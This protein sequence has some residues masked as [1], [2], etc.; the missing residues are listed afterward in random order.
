MDCFKGVVPGMT[1]VPQAISNDTNATSSLFNLMKY[2]NDVYI[3]ST[4]FKERMPKWTDEAK[5]Q[6]RRF[7]LAL[8]GENYRDDVSVAF[9]ACTLMLPFV[10]TPHFDSLNPG[11]AHDITI[12]G[13]TTVNVAEFSE[14][15]QRKIRLVFGKDVRSIPFSAVFYQRRKL[16][17]YNHHILQISSFLSK[18]G[19]DMSARKLAIDAIQNV[20]SSLN[21]NSRFFTRRGYKD[22]MMECT[23]ENE[24]SWF[25]GK[26]G[27]SE[28][29]ID[30]MVSTC[31]S[32]SLIL[33]FLTASSNYLH[34]G[35][36]QQ[37]MVVG[38]VPLLFIEGCFAIRNF[39]KCND[40]LI[41]IFF[42][43]FKYYSCVG[44]SL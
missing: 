9:P 41:Y 40:G 16:T 1:N 32:D 11:G 18:Q 38:P 14:E 42:E 26:C 8:M 37:G 12:L 3:P 4:K 20:D 15:C 36:V 30:K 2:V 13:M 19:R 17:S 43:G 33:Q 35:G 44:R 7:A 34:F 28:E 25:L 23:S 31:I 5:E 21:Y 27:K 39:R 29:A 24:E 22:R 10:V 6:L